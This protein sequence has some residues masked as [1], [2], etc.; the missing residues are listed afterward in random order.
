MEEGTITIYTNRERTSI[1]ESYNVTDFVNEAITKTGDN[2]LYVYLHKNTTYYINIKLNDNFQ[3]VTIKIE[4]LLDAELS[5]FNQSN[6]MS[7]EFI[8]VLSLNDNIDNTSHFKKLII[9]EKGIFTTVVNYEGMQSSDIKVLFFGINSDGEYTNLNT[10]TLNSTKKSITISYRELDAG[11]YC[12]GYYNLD[13]SICTSIYISFSR[14]IDNGSDSV[15]NGLMVDPNAPG[16]YGSQIAIVERNKV[17]KS[18]GETYIT[19]GFTRLLFI[20]SSYDYPTSRTQYEWYSSDENILTVSNYGTV[21]GISEGTAK[22]IGV[23]INNPGIIFIKEFTVVDNVDEEVYIVEINQ[24]YSL[25]SDEELILDLKANN[26]PYP[27]IQYY[28]FDIISCEGEA[29]MLTFGRVIPYTAGK[30]IVEGVYCLNSNYIVKV[31][32]DVTT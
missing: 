21:L 12:I 27:H 17:N 25:S 1:L 32:I 11:A 16:M 18:Y 3:D 26:C 19:K 24:A 14:F 20:D 22:V 4:N 30:I 28:D 15:Y 2:S 31:T 9:K 7:A 23:N 6:I 8:N 29:D 10:L 13:K 5:I